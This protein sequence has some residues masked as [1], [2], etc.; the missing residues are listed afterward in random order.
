MC[1]GFEG[2]IPRTLNPPLLQCNL[3]ERSI[4]PQ[5]EMFVFSEIRP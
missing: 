1:N 2:N 5:T 4:E 3:L